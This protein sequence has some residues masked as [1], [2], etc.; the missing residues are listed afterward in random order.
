[1]TEYLY[2]F[3][4]VEAVLTQAPQRVR[5]LLLNAQRGDAR[6]SELDGLAQGAGV[7]IRRVAMTEL[8]R[9]VGDVSHQGVVA[10]I[11]PAPELDE[12]DLYERLASMLGVDSHGT[13]RS[14]A[15]GLAKRS[16]EAPLLLVLDEVTDPR[17]FGALL[18]VADG[19]GVHAV[20]T[21]RRNSP[22]L[23]AVV[24]KS[25][26]G[27]ALMVPIYR[28]T[29]LAR[30]LGRL[31]QLGVWLVGLDDAAAQLWHETDLRV[32]TALVLG[33]EGAGMRRLTREHCDLLVKLPMAGVAASLNVSVA[34]GVALYEA[35]RQ[36]GAA[37][38]R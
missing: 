27:A 36:R 25:S 4:V 8:G 38:A 12:E 26:A 21:T 33:A 7:D 24:H 23:T 3:H 14:D 19:A 6:L 29:N 15:A 35:R 30:A 2:G 31:Q 16:R 13:P 17:N 28:V 32:A 5:Q 10:E 18:R 9:L 37:A 20:V 1:M 11:E 22:P 34:A